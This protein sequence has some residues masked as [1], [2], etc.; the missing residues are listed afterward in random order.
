MDNGF[1]ILIILFERT[2]SSR[3]RSFGIHMTSSVARTS[4]VRKQQNE[5]QESRP[6][7]VP[8]HEDIC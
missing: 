7:H 1:E 6:G 4:G 2:K 3:G 5:N 8:G